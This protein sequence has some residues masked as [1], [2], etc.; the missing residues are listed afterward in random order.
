MNDMK[1]IINMA[2]AALVILTLFFA[3]SFVVVYYY[4]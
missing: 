1:V 3:L 4:M 2:K